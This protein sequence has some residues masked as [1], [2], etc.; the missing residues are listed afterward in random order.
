[1]LQLVEKVEVEVNVGEMEEIQ[2]EC[3][4]DVEIG[5]VGEISLL[6]MRSL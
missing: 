2:I 5:H 6:Q 1:M 3:V 4:E